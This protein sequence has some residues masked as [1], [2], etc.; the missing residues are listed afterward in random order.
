MLIHFA[1]LN[2]SSRL[3][4]PQRHIPVLI[5]G[6]KQTVILVPQRCDGDNRCSMPFKM[7]ELVVRLCGVTVP[8]RADEDAT[9]FLLLLVFLRT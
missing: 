5:A 1:V 9:F 3:T 4:P 6:N 2:R 7:L 8:Q